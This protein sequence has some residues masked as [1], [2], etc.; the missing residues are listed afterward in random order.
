VAKHDV[1]SGTELTNALTAT[2][3]SMMSSCAGAKP[4]LVVVSDGQASSQPDFDGIS[5]LLTGPAR[6]VNVH[7]IAMNENQAF[8][9]ARAFWE[10]PTNGLDSIAAV[11]GFGSDEIA[12]AVAGILSAETGQQVVAR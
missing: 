4:V 3:D 8:E 2:V 12:A 7:L 10:D 9:S 1:G 5:A 6:D 11:T